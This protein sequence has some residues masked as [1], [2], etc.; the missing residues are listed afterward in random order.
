MHPGFQAFGPRCL[1]VGRNSRRGGVERGSA[2]LVT[3]QQIS[4]GAYN[5]I[6]DPIAEND[7][8]FVQSR[9]IYRNLGMR[10]AYVTLLYQRLKWI[11]P[12]ARQAVSR[13]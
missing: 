1:E 10:F 13:F 11:G 9:R 8:E 12:S 5:T 6:Y 4:F 3:S 2:G 7:S